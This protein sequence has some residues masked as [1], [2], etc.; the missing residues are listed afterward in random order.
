MDEYRL[1]RQIR[2]LENMERISNW[3]VEMERPTGKKDRMMKRYVRSILR[4]KYGR[5]KKLGALNVEGKLD[6]EVKGLRDLGYY[7]SRASK[8]VEAA[9][10]GSRLYGDGLELERI[11]RKYADVH[12]CSGY[13]EFLKKIH[14][15][16]TEKSKFRYLEYLSELNEY[17]GRFIKVKYPKMF[18]KV[19][20]SAPKIISRA[21]A[22]GF[23]K[24]NGMEGAEWFPKVYCVKCGREISRKVFRY[25]LEGKRHCREGQGKEEV[26]Y[27]GMPVSEAES[28]VLKSLAI[29]EKERKHSISLLSRRKKQTK[30][31]VPRWL[32]RRKDLDIAFE[33]E[34][35]GYSG[36]GR[37]RFDR[38]FEEDSHARGVEM[39][40]A[41]YCRVL[42]GITRV[43]ILM[44]MKNRMEESESYSEEF[45]DEEGNVFDKRTY[46]DLKRNNLI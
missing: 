43:G 8:D 10:K 2:I 19:V 13:R 41:K 31:S 11:F 5:Y 46:E 26:L 45:E 33:C 3:I 18:R 28:L 24:K 27:C 29:L 7:E 38:H 39:Y 16:D 40:G 23:G 30:S 14:R 42:K 32:C 4:R 1:G 15:L 22:R 44:K 6:G 21:E 34:I 25:H 37:D 20:A 36:Y 17:L 35:C 12:L 9:F